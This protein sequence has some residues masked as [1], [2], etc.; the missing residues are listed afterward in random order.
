MEEETENW[1]KLLFCFGQ[2]TQPGDVADRVEAAL[3]FS[4]INHIKIVITRALC[5]QT[6]VQ[7]LLDMLM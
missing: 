6:A 3:A 7:L 5:G 1:A 4:L 2:S